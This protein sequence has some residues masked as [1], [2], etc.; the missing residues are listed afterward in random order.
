MVLYLGLVFPFLDSSSQMHCF[1][2]LMARCTENS[3]VGSLVCI[4]LWFLPRQT[5]GP[6]HLSSFF[7]FS[8]TIP[9]LPVGSYQC[10]AFKIWASFSL[11]Y[12][13]FT[14]CPKVTLITFLLVVYFGHIGLIWGNVLSILIYQRVSWISQGALVVKNLPASAVDV[15]DVGLIPGSGRSSGEGNGNLIQYS[16]LENPTDW[17]G[18]AACICGVTKSQT[19]LNTHIMNITLPGDNFSLWEHFS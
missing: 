10:S 9:L 1:P 2:W 17:G 14:P 12:P 13:R 8:L 6:W 18:L 5:W 15:R 7:F 16:C 19:W 11:S 4:L 3:C